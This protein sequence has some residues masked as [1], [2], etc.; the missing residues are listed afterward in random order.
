M[1]RFFRLIIRES[2]NILLRRLLRA[3]RSFPPNAATNHLNTP[4][5]AD[6][7]VL[8]YSPSII[9]LVVANSVDYVAEDLFDC[10]Q[11]W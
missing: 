6:R 5:E 8:Q 4:I 1:L 2:S 7:V 10:F 3:F 11:E 9:V